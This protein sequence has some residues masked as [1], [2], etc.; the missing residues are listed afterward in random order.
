LETID[1]AYFFKYIFKQRND[2]S[3]MESFQNFLQLNRLG[4]FGRLVLRKQ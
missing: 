3:L 1:D 2:T 4:T